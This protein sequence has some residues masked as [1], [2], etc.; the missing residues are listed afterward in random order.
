ML[1]EAPSVGTADT[2]AGVVPEAPG[3]LV[4]RFVRPLIGLER[5]LHYAL[6]PLGT[7]YEPYA[8]LVSMDEPDLRL[9][10]VPPGV[11]FRDYVIEIPDSDRRLLDLKDAAD[12]AVLGIVRRHGV[13]T[14]VVN[15]MGPIVVNRTTQL[16]AQVVLQESDYGVM[17][18]VDAGIAR[19]R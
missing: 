16:A 10:V 12:V 1:A 4:L 9:V 2:P 5:S 6:R 3:E 13:P 15:L 8:S 17:V 19:P 7:Q 11:I 18:P 14:P